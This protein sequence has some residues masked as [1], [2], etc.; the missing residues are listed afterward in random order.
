LC[1]FFAS[2]RTLPKKNLLSDDEI[3][4]IDNMLE[5]FLTEVTPH[6]IYN[7]QRAHGYVWLSLLP[8]V[9]LA[10]AGPSKALGTEDETE[11]ISPYAFS[12]AEKMGL[13]CLRHLVY[14]QEDREQFKKEELTGYLI[15]VCWFAKR[16]PNL[17][18][19]IPKLEQFEQLQPPRL[20]TIAKAY[21]LKCFGKTHLSKCFSETY[22]SRL[23]GKMM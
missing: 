11:E 12:S 22:L 20:G 13:F 1:L 4:Q 6:E 17:A 5:A 3:Q 21:L 2:L 9:Q 10:L 18:E 15:C 14:D 23:F 19:L 7:F 16:C 8:F